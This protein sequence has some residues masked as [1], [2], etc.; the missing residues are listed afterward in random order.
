M[1][2]NDID[3]DIPIIFCN[4]ESPKDLNLHINHPELGLFTLHREGA[5][6]VTLN[7]LDELFRYIK[8][9]GFGIIEEKN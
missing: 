3:D 5:N 8:E 9:H 1:K 4:I 2:E 6:G 7:E